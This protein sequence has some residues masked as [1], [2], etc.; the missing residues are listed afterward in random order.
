MQIIV[1]YLFFEDRFAFTKFLLTENAQR[2]LIAAVHVPIKVVKN[3]ARQRRDGSLAAVRRY[4]PARPDA[5]RDIH[6]R[7]PDPAA[8]PAPV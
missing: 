3:A 4:S 8:R 7:G 1:S 6:R 2:L 5:I